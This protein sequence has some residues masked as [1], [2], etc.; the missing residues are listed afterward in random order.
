MPRHCRATVQSANEMSRPTSARNNKLHEW[1]NDAVPT[2]KPA[3]NEK[4]VAHTK[5]K[6]AVQ[7]TVI[8]LK[9]RRA[10]VTGHTVHHGTI[11]RSQ[12]VSHDQVGILAGTFTYSRT[13]WWSDAAGNGNGTC[14]HSQVPQFVLGGTQ[15]DVT[16]GA[17]KLNLLWLCLSP[18][19]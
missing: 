9:S 5:I 8:A 19:S 18:L 1:C 17:K 13:V 11:S 16:G 10:L 4:A 6:E 12:E 2:G 7:T 14:L 15:G 3:R